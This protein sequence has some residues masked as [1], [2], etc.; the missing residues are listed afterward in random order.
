MADLREWVAP[1]LMIAIGMRALYH[2]FTAS[3][4]EN[5]GEGIIPPEQRRL[6]PATRASRIV[7]GVMSTLVI[8]WG[9]YALLR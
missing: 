6:V 9:M 1:L 7:L 2:A 8:G 5:I 4:F 3:H